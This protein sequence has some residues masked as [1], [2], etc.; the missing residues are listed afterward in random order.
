MFSGEIAENLPN[1]HIKS[2]YY[3]TLDN[4]CNNK[5]LLREM[6]ENVEP[7]YSLQHRKDRQNYL[8]RVHFIF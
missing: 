7:F 4:I 6:K 3:L 5:T 8:Q 1:I 2:S